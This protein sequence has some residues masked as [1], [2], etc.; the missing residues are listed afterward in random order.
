MGKKPDTE[1]SN[2]RIIE[3]YVER[4]FLEKYLPLQCACY[5]YFLFRC[6]QIRINKKYIYIKV[7]MK[8]I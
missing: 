7:N 1:I 3:Y 2:C 8:F 6:N 4:L 5:M